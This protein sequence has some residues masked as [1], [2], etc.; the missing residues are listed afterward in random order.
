MLSFLGK[1]PP[2]KAKVV[3]WNTVPCLVVS[4]QTSEPPMLWHLDLEKTPNVTLSLRE[5]D[6]EWEFGY[7]PA[8]KDFVPV[9]CFDDH[10][11]AQESYAKIEKTLLCGAPSFS[12]E[13]LI[14]NILLLVFLF[15]VGMG[16]LAFIMPSEHASDKAQE[17]RAKAAAVVSEQA[18]PSVPVDAATD[19]DAMRN[20]V[21]VNA[22]D[23]LPK[24]VE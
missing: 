10:D 9:Y 19:H 4:F 15:V 14:K 24:D 21:P 5:K 6:G 13:R 3:H 11:E 12:F 16:V 20:G 22:D 8:E 2:V 18:V 23:V 17:E 1:K 7:K